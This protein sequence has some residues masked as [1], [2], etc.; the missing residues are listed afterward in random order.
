[1]NGD[2]VMGAKRAMRFASE[3]PDGPGSGLHCNCKP[4]AHPGM[5]ARCLCFIWHESA[6]FAHGTMGLMYHCPMS[7]ELSRAHSAP[8]AV[9]KKTASWRK[10]AGAA[11]AFRCV[12]SF[13]LVQGPQ[14]A[15]L[16]VDDLSIGTPM[17][18]WLEPDAIVVAGQAGL[19]RIA[20]GKEVRQTHWPESFATAG[21][22]PKSSDGVL[23]ADRTSIDL[24]EVVRWPEQ[25]ASGER[26][27]WRLPL[28]QAAKTLSFGTGSL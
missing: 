21:K 19:V 15:G 14:G 20:I 17:G 22:K 24:M 2:E 8:S 3:K 6:Q 26:R 9:P 7:M 1:M 4:I 27:L 13:A 28:L 16:V 25:A 12:T 10:S 11:G 18:A 5:K 23:G